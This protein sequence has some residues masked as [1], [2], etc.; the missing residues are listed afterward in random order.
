MVGTK[1]RLLC[2]GC[3]LAWATL[4]KTT[5]NMIKL[6]ETIVMTTEHAFRVADTALGGRH[7]ALSGGQ[8][9]LCHLDGPGTLPAPRVK[10]V[11]SLL[12]AKAW[13]WEG[14]ATDV[15]CGRAREAAVVEA[16]SST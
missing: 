13:S 3:R 6:D 15:D 4:I 7:D 9:L 16:S 14:A 12:P 8:A 5:H 11:E 10:R 1:G 2:L